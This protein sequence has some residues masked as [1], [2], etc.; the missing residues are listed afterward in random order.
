MGLWVMIVLA[1]IGM[2]SELDFPSD[3][4]YLKE[5]Y[6]RGKT[7]LDNLNRMLQESHL[8]TDQSCWR[9]A[10]ENLHSSCKDLKQDKQS[11]LAFE[12]TT[13]YTQMMGMGSYRCGQDNDV[14][15]CAESFD[16]TVSDIFHKYIFNVLEICYFLQYKTWQEKTEEAENK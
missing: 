4:N 3:N 12:L 11:R 1:L 10:L 6:T 13:C 5:I 2:S 9:Q 15:E 16:S 8:P 14:Q 7:E